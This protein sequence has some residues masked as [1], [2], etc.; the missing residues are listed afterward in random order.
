M[1]TEQN[2]IK[3][4]GAR[5]NNLKN[6]NIE[7]PLGKFIV[8]TGVS[9][10]G[11]SSLA[12]DTVYSEGQR[13]YF[14]TFSAYTR[15]FLDRMDK[16]SVDKIEGI[17]P[18]IAV[19]QTNPV[20][21]SRSTVGTMTELND[22]LK[23]LFSKTARLFC[24]NCGKEVN[25]D[26]PETAFRQ[27]EEHLAGSMENAEGARIIIT[28]PVRIPN[29]FSADEIK[30]IL[31]KEG[32]PRIYSENSYL[33]EVI[34]DRTVFSPE[35]RDRIIEGFEDAF[36]K[37]KGA[38]AVRVVDN[39]KNELKTLRFSTDLHC[40]ECDI[41]YQDPVPNM[42]SF[43]S[44]MGA[45]P[46]CRGFGRTMGIDYDLVIPDK[47]KT[48]SQG[49]VKPF[50]TE[51]FYICQKELVQFAHS[52]GIP[53]DIPYKDLSEEEKQWVI[54]GEEGGYDKGV[55]YGV[56]GYFQWLESK[57]YKMHIRV[58][59]SRYRAYNMCTECN[60]A[61]LKPEPLLWRI[62]GVDEANMNKLPGYNIHEMMQLP[63]DRLASFFFSLTLPAPMDEAA[64][65]VLGEIRSRLRYLCD[66]G[67]GYLTLD[68][69]S[70][71]LSGGEVQRI[72]LTTAL[73]TSLVNTLFVLDEPSIGLHSRDINRLIGILKRLRD[74]G[75]TLIVVE[76]DPEVICAADLV[77]DLGPAAGV[78][79]GEAVFYGTPTEMEAKNASLTGE[80]LA[81][82]RNVLSGDCRRENIVE[83]PDS[84][85][86][87]KGASEHN[88][89]KVNVDIPLH[90]LVSITGV[91]GSGKSTLIQDIL[92]Y[93]IRKLKHKPIEQPGSYR[94]IEG[95]ENIDKI[96]L[97]D[98]RP[99]GKTTRSNPASYVGAFDAIRKL[100]AEE[101]LSRQRGYK[102]GTFS[103]N[104]TKGRCPECGGNGFE[105]V[106]MQ[107]LSD[108]Y[109]RCPECGG[110]RYRKDVLEVKLLPPGYGDIS[111]K[112]AYTEAQSPKSIADVLEMTVDEAV[113]FFKHIP[114]VINKLKPL[115]NVGLGYV[116]LGQPV[117]TLSGGEA[118]RLKLAGYLAEN[119]GKSKSK[120]GHTL[121]LFD[122]PTTGLHFH[123][124]STLLQAFY[125]L[126]DAG[127]SV[128]VIEHNLDVI[129]ASDW[130][131]DLGPEGG[132]QGGAVVCTGTPDDVMECE[133]SFTGIAL[134]HYCESVQKIDADAPDRDNYGEQ[135]L[136]ANVAEASPAKSRETASPYEAGKSK[137]ISVRGAR[138][139]NLRNL[140]L[141]IPQNT[142]TV[143]TGVS[144]SGKSTIAF[145]ILFSEGQ[146]RYLESLNA[147]ARQFVQPSTR[148]EVDGISGLPPTVSIEQRTSRGGWK[149]TVA[150]VTELY[151][152]IRLLFVRLGRQH[153]PQCSVPI[154]VQ[155]VEHI[156]S[157]LVSEYRGQIVEIG[158]PMVVSRK[159]YY[160]DL[161]GWAAA[162]GYSHLRVDGIL[163]PTDNWPR[164]DRYKEHT[165]QLP[166]FRGK[167]E[168]EHQDE[169]KNAVE[170]SLKLGKE[171]MHL[172][173]LPEYNAQTGSMV[174]NEAVVF[175]TKRVCPSCGRSFPELDP[176]LFSYNSKHG[177][178]PVCLGTGLAEDGAGETD[179]DKTQEDN[180][181]R[182]YEEYSCKA[183][184]GSRL[185]P[186]ALAVTFLE[187]NIDAYNS[188][189]I[190]EAK[191]FFQN[192]TLSGREAEVA[193]DVI[194]ELVGR[195]SFL[196]EVG[197]SYLSLNRAAPTLSG[198]EAQRIK[199]ASQLGSNLRGV[200]YILDEPTIGLH[201]RD[202]RMLLNTLEKLRDKGNTVVVVEHDDAVIRR[203][204]HVIDIGPG[205]G[206]HGGMLVFSG[207]VTSL[208]EN[209]NSI[210]GRL[211]KNP[212]KHPLIEN[213][214]REVTPMQVPCGET[215]EAITVCGAYTHN[216]KHI[217]AHFPL[218]R[219]ICITGVSGSGKSTLARA[220]LKT[221]G[222]KLLKKD[223]DVLPGCKDIRGIE[224]VDRIL[225][226]D[227]TPIGK[228]PRSCPATY[229]GVWDEVRKLFAGIPEARMRGY[230]PSRFSF[231]VKGGRCEECSGQGVK[232]IEM[233]FL[234]DVS[235]ECEVCGGKRFNQETL[236][237]TYH[238]KNISDV[239]EMS[240]EEAAEFFSSIPSVSH[241]LKMLTDVGL[242]YLRIGQQSPTLS[243]GEAQRLKLVTELSKGTA[244]PGRTARKPHTLYILD[245]PTIGL[246]MADVEKLLKVLH[247][248][249]DAGNTVVIIE[250][251][252]DIIA[253]A[254]YIIDLGPEGGNEG[255]Y[256]AA[257]GSPRKVAQKRNGSHTA[258]ALREFFYYTDSVS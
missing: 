82:K 22:H 231:N 69:Q 199:L 178:C 109:L 197:L 213:E 204:E 49:A 145:D 171:T 39:R 146:R 236:E 161:A 120:S 151:H 158:A 196:E 81:G 201:V 135:V 133:K 30:D 163:E 57:S 184:E 6:L 223:S 173:V 254:D 128:T 97:V 27:V 232:K 4:Y 244:R 240:V 41:H 54:E 93:A 228:T 47:T 243:G 18:A 56:K 157:N 68:R 123:D 91:S 77:L 242:G 156:L 37:G 17:P 195:L 246:H 154:S 85:I 166:V 235:V 5:Q 48:L 2:T 249:V 162:R 159:G 67:L 219:F 190:T 64:D 149:S 170:R 188:M 139:H 250:H 102:A 112:D 191:H 202:N 42:F 241:A 233:S 8:I 62:T 203:A 136:T 115:I 96:V 182:Y 12:F 9:G 224:H 160:T 140:D 174:Q 130:L 137:I 187:K 13:R 247:R 209:K 153:C 144:G 134:K 169:I 124:I 117:P 127:H 92:Y 185:R 24:R 234:P 176:R 129:R 107:F 192:L 164:L 216:L 99:I 104:S 245:E 227:Q 186:E 53:T 3:I 43:N 218:Q 33:L 229:L 59:L 221:S 35:R 50:Q 16:P 88:L 207:S 103:F 55:W 141:T 110:T 230:T 217:D 208:M 65:I 122:E 10:S 78:A 15:Q 177:W 194:P 121:F 180:K 51:S 98:Q 29:N 179:N 239:L 46:V 90:K 94:A 60:G 114:E 61:R 1:S 19:D 58:L 44:P 138:E 113:T 75:N 142:F 210:T 198:G 183:C 126:L 28:F 255:G 143:I 23:L 80:Y 31:S 119:S 150:T 147:Y 26:T 74:E 7:F 220:V 211:L 226:V 21:T 168:P 73:G 76:H 125:R 167:V 200:C 32:Y 87:I 251:N 175:S 34:K 256:I 237:V 84:V 215:E 14:E 252:M 238:D 105:H 205:G 248:L 52:R 45:C 79:G 189:T 222:K 155:S 66:V 253:E 132:E 152:F 40:P 106:E 11:K 38:A 83:L 20:K 131:I 89:K 70:R 172:F 100:F 36:S 212:L 225:E 72:N 111:D 71:T 25:R 86:S 258:E 165:I 63:L 148:P 214:R 257:E 95:Y 206:V 101:P 193:Q 118:Q 181:E 116:S 108:V